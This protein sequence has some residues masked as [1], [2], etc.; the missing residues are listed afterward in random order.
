MKPPEA[1][2]R[3]MALVD[4]NSFYC[5]AERVFRPDL[6]HVPLVVLSNSD[7][8]VVAR[9]SLVRQMGVPVGQ[10]W[11]QLRD[12]ARRKGWPIVAMSSNYTLYGD[13]SRRVMNVL[14]GYVPAEDQE[15]YSIDECFLDFTAQPRLNLVTTG[16]DIKR[17][18]KQWTGL[19]VCVGFGPTKT[20]AKLANRIA[21]TQPQ[22]NG[23]CDL[24][25]MSDTEFDAVMRLVKVEDVWGI[26][27]KLSEALIQAGVTTAADL[28]R[29]DAKRIR[30][31]FN[32]VVERTVRELQGVPCVAWETAP[33]AKQQIISS[34]SFGAPV[35]T[36]EELAEPIRMHAGRAAEK[37]RQQGSAAA[38]VGIWIETNRFRPQDP[39]YCPMRWINLPGATDDTALLTTWAVAVLRTVFKQGFRYVKAGVML[40]DI[41]PKGLAQGLL[42]DG[43][44]PEQDLRREK[45]MSVL[46]KANERWGRGTMGIG[47]AG[48]RAPRT[49][50]MRREMLSP[51]YTTDWDQLRVV[52]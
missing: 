47:S 35:Y 26:G 42:F 20:L 6:E 11:Y 40:D 16:Q 31:R 18:V 25:A 29:V 14:A 45:L 43:L 12:E 9:D 33:P 10:P 15:V 36:V 48:V 21:K 41:R 38:R 22:F 8:C 30:E 19:P 39:Q 34:R 13:L 44:P 4:C 50:T 23:V 28:R 3:R 24:T 17:R 49:W 1:P 51:C 27:R 2:P 32:V 52:T 5:S 37:L 7:G 46:D